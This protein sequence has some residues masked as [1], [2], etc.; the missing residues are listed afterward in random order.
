MWVV[1]GWGDGCRLLLLRTVRVDLLLHL[2]VA[3]RLAVARDVELVEGRDRLA[4][5]TAGRAGVARRLVLVGDGLVRAAARVDGHVVRARLVRDAKLLGVLV[6]ARVVAAVARAAAGLVVAAR[7]DVLDGEHRLRE[8]G[9]VVAVRLRRLLRD[10]VPAVGERRRR[11]HRPA[12]SR[13]RRGCA[14]CGWR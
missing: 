8:G 6:H 4:A 13:S 10:D 2:G 3:R 14:G 11:A 9:R 5:R 7:D 12:R 1:R